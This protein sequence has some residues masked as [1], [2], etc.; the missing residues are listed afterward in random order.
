MDALATIRTRLAPMQFLVTPTVFE[1]MAHKAEF[2]PDRDLRTLAKKGLKELRPRWQ[3]QP[4]LL[5]A[6]QEAIV[7]RSATRLQQAGL[8]PYEE[9]N[10]AFL[11]T[12]ASV[13]NCILLV[14]HDSHLRGL[15]FQRLALLFGELDL[16]APII[17][18]PTEV[19]RKFYR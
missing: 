13:L 14:T 10:D 7:S 11:L 1:E 4:A 17:A 16:I 18:T 5:N 19:L 8:L 9:R 12:E 2:E 6:V 15:D 3:I